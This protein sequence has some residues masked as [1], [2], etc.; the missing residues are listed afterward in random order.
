MISIIIPVFNSESTIEILVNYIIKTLGEN[1]KFEIILINDFIKNFPASSGR[2]VFSA[3]GLR[4]D[5]WDPKGAKRGK[6]DAKGSS[7]SSKNVGVNSKTHM[8][9]SPCSN[10]YKTCRL[11]M[12]LGPF[13]QNGT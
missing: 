9:K 13:W 10:P 5:G 3:L 12:L 2:R 6:M 8:V 11:L 7:K 4:P 1:Y